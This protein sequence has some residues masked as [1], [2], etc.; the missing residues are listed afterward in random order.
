MLFITL[1]TI[2]SFIIIDNELKEF[3]TKKKTTK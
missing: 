1:N 3:A 2:S